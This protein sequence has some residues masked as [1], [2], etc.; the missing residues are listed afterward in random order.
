MGRPV[1]RLVAIEKDRFHR[2]M[3]DWK[4]KDTYRIEGAEVY[5]GD[6]DVFVLVAPKEWCDYLHGKREDRPDNF[7]EEFEV[8]SND[9][10]LL[11]NI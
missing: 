10:E 3:Q 7:D 8:D 4:I 1:R 9:L 5:W 2:A 11:F 6:D